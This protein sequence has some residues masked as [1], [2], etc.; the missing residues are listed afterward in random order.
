MS[1]SATLF[2]HA[3]GRNWLVSYSH[4]LKPAPDDHT[5]DPMPISDQI[6][7]RLLPPKC[8]GYLTRDPLCRRV[9]RDI[10]P[11]QP[12]FSASSQC[13]DL[14]GAAKIARTEQSSSTMLP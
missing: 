3:V 10:D 13:S 11:D 7:W 1:R 2:C 4:G 14:N 5:E 8:L 6:F 12:S 9:R